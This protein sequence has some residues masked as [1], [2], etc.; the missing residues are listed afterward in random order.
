MRKGW[1]KAGGRTAIR[2]F[3]LLLLLALPAAL[4]AA[5]LRVPAEFPTIKSA[6]GR[7]A[8]GDTVLVDDGVYLEKNI[9]I[10][11]AVTVRSRNLFG[12]VIYGSRRAEDAVF[13]VRA[14]ARIEGFVV[15]G[16]GVGILQRGSPD[17]EWR[18]SDLVFEDCAIGLSIDDA[19]ENV[20][21][22]VVRHVAVLGRSHSAGMMTNDARGLDA[23]DCLV[24]GCRCAFEGYDHL[25][26]RVRRSAVVDCQGA[27]IGINNHRPVWPASSRMEAG[28]G[29]R[30]LTSRS[31]KDPARMREF[32]AFLDDAVF[33]A[34]AEGR[35][36]AGD[37]AAR[38]SVKALVLGRLALARQ[39]YQNAAERFEDARRA[40]ER[41][42]SREF[43]WQALAG[44]GQALRS[45]GNSAAARES[46]A[47]AIDHLERWVPEVP[48]GLHRINF[49]EDKTGAFE[50]LLSLFHE[51]R[52]QD[53]SRRWDEPALACAEKLRALSRQFAPG[54]GRRGR[55]GWKGPASDPDRTRAK[56]EAGAR[57]SELQIALQDPDLTGPEK[58][59]LVI[60]LE[61][62][63]E[64]YHGALVAEERAVPR[65]LGNGGGSGLP[66]PVDPVGLKDRLAGRAVLSYILGEEGSYAFLA[67]GDGLSFARLPAAGELAGLV[68]P[69]LK[70]LQLE[71]GREFPGAK[72]GR[73]LYDKLLGPFEDELAA[74][75]R[76]IIVVPDGALRYLPFE[77]LVMDGGDGAGGPRFWA[78]S[79]D[80]SYAASVAEALADQAADDRAEA[81][82]GGTGGTGI[83]PKRFLVVGSPDGIRCDNRS[84]KIKQFFFPLAG[85]GKEVRAVTEAI[86]DRQATVLADEAAGERAF[87]AA[88]LDGFGLIHVASHGVIDDA[89]WWRSALLL[90]P[91]AGG[92]AGPAAGPEDGFL[93]ALEI[94]ELALDARLVVL[95]GCGTGT[96]SLFKGEGIK[97]LSEAFRRAGT[98][99][100]VV[101]LWSVDDRA[102]AVFMGRF[103]RR[104]AAGDPPARAL[105]RAK[106]EM[107]ASRYGSPFHWAAFV[108]TGLAADRPI[109]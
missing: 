58:D 16:A 45:G 47:A 67:T 69:Y 66:S 15:K 13:I 24:V 86:P 91:E 21:S 106:R 40:A 100:L 93:T 25:S 64:E 63:E 7:A 62:A 44:A 75:P 105:G 98:D 30:V 96:G 70:F 60:R 104:L 88:G 48:V 29:V 107:I 56:A 43:V 95:S 53:G 82:T 22:A 83:R 28:E 42:G 49:L 101:S 10:A 89:N 32:A 99:S 55:A 19:G 72:A 74:K 84:R 68:E 26:F 71:D 90:R 39:D 61:K 54:P 59:G 52:V 38:D 8:A 46:Y 51:A 1:A 94:S 102:T 33:A 77:A 12:A 14:A 4:G 108:L 41:A 31:L 79:A 78:E 57:I 65:R 97:G 2:A 76:R 23:A 35:G 103:Y 37:E 109:R 73:L 87:K 9:E 80:I 11:A 6:V 18:A 3:A 92:A 36:S 85:V 20:G 34:G 5:V 17:V 81:R 50:S 27:L